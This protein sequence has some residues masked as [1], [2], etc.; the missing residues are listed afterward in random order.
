MHPLIVPHMMNGK[1]VS[2]ATRGLILADAALRS[3]MIASI[4][5]VEV[6]DPEENPIMFNVQ[7]KEITNLAQLLNNPDVSEPTIMNVLNKVS[8]FRQTRDSKT[9]KLLFMFMDMVEI[10]RLVSKLMHH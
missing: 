6:L 8:E 10:L 2:R 5:D 4:Y 3:V 7:D 1:A 9:A